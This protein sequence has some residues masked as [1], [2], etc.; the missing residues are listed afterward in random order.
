MRY[1]RWLQRTVELLC[2][3][4]D[5]EEKTLSGLAYPSSTP[6]YRLANGGT[7]AK[8]KAGSTVVWYLSNKH[9]RRIRIVIDDLDSDIREVAELHYV[10][11]LS[12]YLIGQRIGITPSKAKHKIDYLHKVVSQRL[13]FEW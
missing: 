12:P 5:D 2:L 4:G 7:G 9:L 1:K 6:E 11:K 8:A 3:W 13:G 10:I